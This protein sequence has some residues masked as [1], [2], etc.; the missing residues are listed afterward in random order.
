[1]CSR[2]EEKEEEKFYQH[3]DRNRGLFVMNYHF[4]EQNNAK[5]GNTEKKR[6]FFCDI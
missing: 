4:S 5:K 2:E 6:R 1:M 3:R